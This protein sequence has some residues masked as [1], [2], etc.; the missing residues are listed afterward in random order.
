[1][2]STVVDAL[3]VAGID[4]SDLVRLPPII[5][6]DTAPDGRVLPLGEEIPIIGGPARERAARVRLRSIPELWVGDATPPDM[7]DVPPRAYM[8]FFEMVE[9]AAFA[10]CLLT[11]RW[12]T[13]KEFERLYDLLHRRPDGSDDDPLFEHLQAAARLYMSLRDTSRSEFE[14]VLRR[15]ARSARRFAEGHTSRNYAEHHLKS[16]LRA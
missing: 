15:L 14:A 4:T 13:D 10:Y 6:P 3:R 9:I 8:P 5:D 2:D 7:S 16:R 11:G 12:S 1:M